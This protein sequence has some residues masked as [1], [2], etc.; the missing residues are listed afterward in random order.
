[1]IHKN[2][3]VRIL[4]DQLNHMRKRTVFRIITSAFVLTT[5]L[6]NAQQAIE[7]FEAPESVLKTGNRIFVSN[8]GGKQPNPG[9]KDQNGFISEVAANGKVLKKVFQKGM[10]NAPK[11]MAATAAT[12][13]VTDIDRVVGFNLK[14]GQQ[15]FELPIPE[16]S[17]LNDLC[18]AGNNQ[19]AVSESTTGKVYL[20]NTSGKTFRYLDSIPGANGLTY[21]AKTKQL[22]ACGMGTQMNGT[23]KLFVA[24]LNQE[25]PSFTEL[26]ESPTGIFDGL[27]FTDNNHLIVSDWISFSSDKGRLVV[28]DLDHHT[29]T[30][31]TVNAGPADIYFDAAARKVYIPYMPKNR[32]VMERLGRLKRD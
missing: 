9:A 2:D 22:Y 12:L 14:T 15:V 1:M 25:N 29:N 28:Y 23:G 18:K 32:V 17:F 21:R 26:P 7:G 30:S 27:E 10:L 13:Y 24:D 11:G 6:A 3:L 19:L 31:Y 20:I 5:M 4:M 8:I 16:A